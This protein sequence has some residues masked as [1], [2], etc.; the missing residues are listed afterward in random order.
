M[1]NFDKSKSFGK[2]LFDVSIIITSVL[3]IRTYVASAYQVV[4]GSMCNTLNYFDKVCE[5]GKG[6]FL[7]VN[8][9]GTK[10]QSL[11]RGDII[12]FHPPGYEQESYIKRIIG[13]PGET[14]V[15]KGG[16]VSILNSAHPQGFLLTESYL[17][18]ENTNQTYLHNQ[19]EEKSFIIPP[20]H[21]FVLGDNRQGS[22][23]SRTCFDPL[24]N[25]TKCDNIESPFHF[26][27]SSQIEGKAQII[28]WPLSEMKII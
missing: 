8:K 23:D 7:L 5:M 15:I 19:H 16:K 26:V 3:I 4:G 1:K 24:Y 28:I 17:S 9:I 6:D 25:P 14:V 12:V 18:E 13:L 27:E 20:N 2:L 21:Y 11:N 10:I 22:T